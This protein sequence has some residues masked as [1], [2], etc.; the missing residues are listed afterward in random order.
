[1]SS[2]FGKFSD[3][4]NVLTNVR[5]YEFPFPIG[6]SRPCLPDDIYAELVTAR[7]PWEYIAGD[8]K[9]YDNKRYDLCGMRAYRD[10]NIAQIWK[11]FIIYHLSPSF[12][13]QIVNKFGGF[14]EQ[15]YPEIDFTKL[16]PAPRNSD[17][18][19]DIYLDCQIGINTP[20][21]T[22]GTV[23]KPH[24]DG[25]ESVW[26][27]MLYMKEPDDNAGGHLR[28]YKCRDLPIDKG[29]RIM[30]EAGLIESA[31]FLYNP[32]MLVSFVNTP[33]SI[34]SVTEREIT[35]KPRLFVNFTLEFKGRKF[36]SMDRMRNV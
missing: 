19:G 29:E 32:N 24:L 28:V 13:V 23:S 31:K 9:D 1:M 7:P 26:A 2:A 6:I 3:S 11:D 35:E 5:L 14:F 20:A 27:A 12:Y 18:E 21:K 22:K 4:C 30:D 36:F 17:M 16:K 8:K 15:Y 34:H 25:P 10:E 33:F